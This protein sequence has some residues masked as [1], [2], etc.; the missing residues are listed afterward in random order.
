METFDRG[1]ER[2]RTDPAAAREIFSDAAERFQILIDGGIQNGKLYYNLANACLEAGQ[3]GRAIL[4]YRRAQRLLPG[5]GRIEHN[6]TY[7]R[8]LRQDQIQAT[9]Q[10]AFLRTLFFWHYN[11]ALRTRYVLAVALYLA[12]WLLLIARTFVPRLPWRYVLLPVLLIWLAL[13]ISVATQSLHESTER[14]GVLTASEV[15]VRKGNGRGFEPQ[16]KQPLHEGAEFLIIEQRHDWLNIQLP[17]GKTGW[18]PESDA[19]LI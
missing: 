11:T 5:D 19:E 14:E 8:S 16:F 9:G 13:G 10:R 1:V 6:L 12:F 7:A 3:L 18:I 17:D 2:S 15:V 4:N